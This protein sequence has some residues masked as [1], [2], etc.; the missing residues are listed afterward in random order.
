M[1]PGPIIGLS[2][3]NNTDTILDSVDGLPNISIILLN[4][5]NNI[6]NEFWLV[7]FS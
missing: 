1:C 4:K 3:L 6:Y 2:A 5:F 7:D